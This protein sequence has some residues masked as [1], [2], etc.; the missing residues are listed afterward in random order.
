MSQIP[1]HK[2]VYKTDS[3]LMKMLSK[4]LFFNKNFLTEFSTTL[5]NT[6]YLTNKNYVKLHP[7]TIKVTLAH[8]LVHVKDF[9]KIGYSFYLLYGLPQILCLLTPLFLFLFPFWFSM[10]WLGLCL[11]PLPA[12]FRMQLEKK[13]YTFSI[14]ALYLL[15]EKGFAIDFEKNISSYL[16][17][18][19]STN[20][21]WMWPFFKKNY[22]YD[23]LD[24]IRK[25]EKPIYTK[26]YYDMVEEVIMNDFKV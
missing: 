9:N 23:I 7:I 13:A 14:Y 15:S 22:F 2:I 1:Y 5:G 11:L 19:H 24:R 10:F 20:Y 6:I 25:G 26:D 21:Y 4:V 3:K 8:E 12:Y 16:E 17:N 18:F